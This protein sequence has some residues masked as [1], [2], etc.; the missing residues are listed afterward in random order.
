M[1]N[2]NFLN[3]SSL[4]VSYYPFGSTQ[5]GLG[6]VSDT[7][8]DNDLKNRYLFGGKEQDSKT[9]FFEYHFRQYD[10]WLGRW[11]VVDPM[12]EMYGT[13]SPYH[14]AGNNPINNMETNGAFWQEAVADGIERDIDEW[15]NVASGGT[16]TRTT[17]RG[18]TTFF[19]S[20]GYYG[21]YQNGQ[22]TGSTFTGTLGG[23][24][25]MKTNLGPG[26]ESKLFQGADG[27]WYRRKNLVVGIFNVKELFETVRFDKVIEAQGNWVL[28][29]ANTFVDALKVVESLLGTL[30]QNPFE[31]LV[32]HGHGSAGRMIGGYV[33]S[34]KENEDGEKYYEQIFINDKTIKKYSEGKGEKLENDNIEAMFKLISYVKDGG[35]VIFTACNMG[36]NRETMNLGDRTAMRLLY[37]APNVN[38]Y[39]NKHSGNFQAELRADNHVFFRPTVSLD[40]FGWIHPTPGGIEHISKIILQDNF[41]EPVKITK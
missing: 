38:F 5:E 9:G 8:T 4:C 17:Y 26:I 12:A 1:S 2:G 22:Y 7:L 37:M 13:Q 34:D 35:N 19:G 25:F 3:I 18:P 41:Y 36:R 29:I 27:R 39:I 23:S 40:K 15:G 14:F 20:G 10:S 11:H 28:V 33:Q 32:I 31:N 24:T 6:F 30:L 21:N 16:G